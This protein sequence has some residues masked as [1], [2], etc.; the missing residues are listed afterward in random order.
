VHVETF[1]WV[2]ASGGG[3]SDY[4]VRVGR[5]WVGILL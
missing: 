4:V 3:E 1:V 5:G 2:E